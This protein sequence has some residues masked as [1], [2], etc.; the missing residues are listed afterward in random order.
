LTEKYLVVGLGNPGA[1]YTFTR[2]N[3][4]FLVVEEL[5]KRLRG[6]FTRC[7]LSKGVVAKVKENDKD[8]FIL[9]PYTFMNQSGTAVAKWVTNKEIELNRVLVICDDLNLPFGQLR[10]RAGGTS[11][12]HNGLKSIHA[13]L[14]SEDFPRLRVGVGRPQ[15]ETVDYVLG[16]FSKEEKKSLDQII[17][18][19]AEGCLQ[20][21]NEGINKTMDQI[22]RRKDDGKNT[23][24]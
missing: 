24:I 16:E 7:S 21:L 20:W 13:H 15:G 1:D 23:K 5:A 9:K 10:L 17:D 4:G 18:E 22:N 12:G 8:T 11:G 2:H 3:V 19:A 14:Q 6:K